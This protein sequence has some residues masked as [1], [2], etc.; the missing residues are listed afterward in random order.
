MFS[1]NKKLIISNNF[2]KL[3]QEGPNSQMKEE[4]FYDAVDAGLDKLDEKFDEMMVC[5][6]S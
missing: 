4:E 3:L 2:G 6:C 1:Y 5:N